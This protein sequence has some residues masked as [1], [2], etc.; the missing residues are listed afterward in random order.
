MK[1]KWSRKLIAIHWISALVVIGMFASGLWMV[2][3]TYYS[4]WYKTAPHWHKSI[5][6]I[7]FV[8]TA[9]RLLIRLRGDR[10]ASFGN[11]IENMTSKVVQGLIYGLLMVLFL[12]GYLISTADGRAISVFNWFSVPGFGAIV[13][14]QEDIAGDIHF[15]VACTLIGL[16]SLHAIAAFKH[17][18]INKDDTLRQMLRLRSNK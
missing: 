15:Y 3:L 13:E 17:H 18:F 16:A 10:P 1:G 4:D 8:V 2:D 11:R 12:S 14:N 7:L 6:L 5:G 9:Y